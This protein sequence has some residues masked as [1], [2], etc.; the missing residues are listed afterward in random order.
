MLTVFE[1]IVRLKLSTQA[2]SSTFRYTVSASNVVKYTLYSIPNAGIF[3]GS[4]RAHQR[5]RRAV[6]QAGVQASW[7]FSEPEFVN[8]LRSPW[9]DSQPSLTY[10]P[11]RL[12][13]LAESIPWNRFLCSLNVYKY[14]FWQEVMNIELR[15][16]DSKCR[17]YITLSSQEYWKD[18]DHRSDVHGRLR[19]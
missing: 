4:E 16:D 3:E 5:L 12:H 14:G 2:I 11:D 18:Q 8:L 1:T 9:I 6:G 17:L 7:F 10:R 19:A 13:R 15:N